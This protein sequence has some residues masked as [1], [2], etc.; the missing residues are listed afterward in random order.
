MKISITI[1]T[2]IA[3]FCASCSNNQSDKKETPS[4]NE[5]VNAFILKSDSIKK[6]ISLTC[7]ILPY[8]RVQIRSKVSGYIGKINVDIGSVVRKG[9]VLLTIDAPEIK[10]KAIEALNKNNS[11]ESKYLSSKDTYERLIKTSAIKGAVSQ[12]DLQLAKNKFMADSSE[13]QASL[14]SYQSFKELESYLTVRAPFNGTITKRN[15]DE[16]AYVGNPGDK[17][18]LE[19]E[20]NK[21]LRLSV[22]IPEALVGVK[23]VENKVQFSTRAIPDKKF[24]ALLTR[25]AGSI[26][27]TTRSEIWEFQLKNE[28]GIIKSGMFAEVKMTVTR[29]DKTFVVPFSSVLTTLEKKVVIRINNGK[30]Q[31]IDISQ[32]INLPDKTEIFGNLSVGDTIV[33]KANEELKPNT[34]VIAKFE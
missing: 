33:L 20:N 14:Y 15:A 12:N 26:D 32:G 17:P 28:N 2:S 24:T 8:E 3:F 21:M 1:I 19:I 22:A 30:T 7:D 6:Q 16:G 34:K 27:I 9:E 23:L 10:S 11:A 4:K 18:I 13:F 29:E 25:K 5:A 31:W